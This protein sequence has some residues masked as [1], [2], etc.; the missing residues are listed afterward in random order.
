MVRVDP[1]GWAALRRDVVV[2]V[3]VTSDEIPLANGLTVQIG[4][5]WNTH[6]RAYDVAKLVV[7]AGSKEHP[8][9]GV[10]L[11]QIPVQHL[12]RGVVERH[13]VTYSGRGV[14]EP[15]H[16]PAPAGG[17]PTPENLET[18]GLIYDVSRAARDAPAKR[19]AEHFGLPPRTASHWI[20]LARER[21][22]LD[23]APA[24]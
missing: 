12:L 9:T 4:A 14:G 24:S 22:H 13:I 11:R 7:T 10:V 16:I 19:V 3:E 21:G 2:P 8:V 5:S 17:K 15:L 1:F 18:V 6:D 20:K 23:A